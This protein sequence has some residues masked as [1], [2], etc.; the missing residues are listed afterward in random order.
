MG[1][2]TITIKIKPWKEGLSEAVQ[3][4][5][6]IQAG[7]KVKRVKDEYFD[8]LDAVRSVLTEKRLDLIRLVKKFH[9]DSVK[10]LARLAKRDFKQVY[11][12][13][14]RLKEFGLLK[15]TRSKRGVP[16]KLRAE[17]ETINV[18]IAV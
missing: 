14:E 11:D 16:T 10:E 1:L 5:K 18:Q 4:M 7:K 9:P 8:S 13:V 3:V 17:A 12:D 2:K 15:A 6:D